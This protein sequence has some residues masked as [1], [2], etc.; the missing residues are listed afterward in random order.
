M[1]TF[2][3]SARAMVRD[4]MGQGYVDDPVLRI[5][6]SPESSPLAPVWEFTLVEATDREDG[7]TDVDEDGIRV[8]LDAPTAAAVAGSTIDF[9]ERGEARGFE[10]RRA[11]A[12]AFGTPTGPLA[13]RVQKVI[14]ETINPGVAAHGGR[15]TL[16]DVRDNIAYVQML[17]GCQ[18]C[19]MAK[20]TLRQGVERMIRQA[21]PEI[22]AIEDVT[23]HVAGERP[24]YAAAPH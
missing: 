17:G 19:G 12:S 20:V 10:V 7:D 11:G 4:F 14:D 18:G 6:L 3:E 13:E 23:D 16:V 1:L 15:I 22:E 2:T 21:V 24:Y 5:A 8:R 9:V